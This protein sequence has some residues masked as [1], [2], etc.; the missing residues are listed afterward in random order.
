MQ[1]PKIIEMTETSD[2]LKILYNIRASIVSLLAQN[3]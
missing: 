3:I 1:L 2:H